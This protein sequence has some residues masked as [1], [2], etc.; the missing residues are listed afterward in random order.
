MRGVGVDPGFDI[1][2]DPVEDDEPLSQR[3]SPTTSPHGEEPRTTST[4][5]RRNN[6]HESPRRRSHSLA[7]SRPSRPSPC[8]RSRGTERD[9]SS[10]TPPQGRRRPLASGNAPDRTGTCADTSGAGNDPERRGVTGRTSRPSVEGDG[11]IP[12]SRCGGCSGPVIEGHR[13]VQLPC[14]YP[15][16]AGRDFHSGTWWRTL[17]TSVSSSQMRGPTLPERQSAGGG[18]SRPGVKAEG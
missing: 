16:H 5:S 4:S 6:T 1:D 13:V 15:I 18:P 3:R 17:T 8:Q 14:G 12:P 10:S 7:P 11:S 2:Y 9:R